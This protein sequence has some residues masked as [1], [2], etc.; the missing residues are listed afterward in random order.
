[1]VFSNLKESRSDENDLL[2]EIKAGK[3]SSVVHLYDEYSRVLYG[4][5]RSLGARHPQAEDVLHDVFLQLIRKPP[6]V[7]SLKELRSYLFGCARSRFFNWR[8]RFFTRKEMQS[9][10]HSPDI[11]EIKGHATSVEDA[12][13]IEEALLKLPL[14]Q[15][16]VVIMKIHGGLTFEEIAEVTEVS[17]NTAA[18]RYRYA[19]E[20]LRELLTKP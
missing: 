10:N 14:A 17:I 16:E 13:I 20:K 18:S 6:A 3:K 19:V 8:R 4:Y 5:V 7:S 11:F 15:R 2:S 9:D 1:M 12:K